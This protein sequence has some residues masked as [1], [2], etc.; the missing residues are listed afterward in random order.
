MNI[1]LGA[2]VIIAIVLVVWYVKFRKPAP[3]DKKSSSGKK[4][5]KQKKE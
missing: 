4:D 2:I 3:A 5:K 1:I